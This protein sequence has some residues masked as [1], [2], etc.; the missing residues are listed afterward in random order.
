MSFPKDRT[1]K[2]IIPG[3]PQPP[4]LSNY[5][6]S[7]CD[8]VWGKYVKA[9]KKYVDDE[10]HKRLKAKK[11]TTKGGSDL[12]G[13]QT[14]QLRPISKVEKARLSVGDT[15]QSNDVVKLRIA[16]EA[17]LRGILMRVQQSDVMNLTVVGLH[18][19]IHATIFEHVGWCIAAQEI[20]SAAQFHCSFHRRQNII[21]TLGGGKG[22]TPNTPLWLYNLL[23]GC[24]C[25]A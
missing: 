8:S 5:P 9:R 19:Y 6:E 20:P 15:F 12:S 16:E 10:C 11:S 3:G 24:H 23:C 17:N 14:E 18:F 21:R 4:V 1:G 7:V 2:T 22:V 13:D 25:T